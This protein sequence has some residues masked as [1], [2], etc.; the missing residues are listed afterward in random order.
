MSAYYTS[1]DHFALLPAILLG[2]FGCAIFGLVVGI[3]ISRN[4]GD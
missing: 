4:V 1:L 3:R 2:L